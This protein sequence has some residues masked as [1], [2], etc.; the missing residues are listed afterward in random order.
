ML[1]FIRVRKILN[2]RVFEDE[3]GR[4]W[5]RSVMDREL[6][7]LC[8]SQFTLQCILKANK[9]DFHSAMPAEL[10]QP[11]Y[12]SMLEQMREAYKPELIKGE[13][14]PAKLWRFHS[15]DED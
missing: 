14:R 11:F 5:S 13:A 7:V 12:N 9:P 8:V 3:N 15:A 2:L 4:A 1:L 10:A 6:E